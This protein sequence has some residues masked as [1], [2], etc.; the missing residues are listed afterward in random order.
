[1]ARDWNLHLESLLPVTGQ[2]NT[3]GALDLGVDTQAFSY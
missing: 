3:T 1:M 2:S